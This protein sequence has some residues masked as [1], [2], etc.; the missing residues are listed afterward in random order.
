MKY[1]MYIYDFKSKLFRERV[2]TGDRDGWLDTFMSYTDVRNLYKKSFNEVAELLVERCKAKKLTLDKEL[3][4]EIEYVALEVAYNNDAEIFAQTHIK[5]P[6]LDLM[7][8]K[9]HTY[10]SKDEKGKKFNIRLC[11]YNEND[12][13]VF[14]GY[15]RDIGN[16]YDEYKMFD[17]LR[18]TLEDNYGMLKW[19][20]DYKL[21]MSDGVIKYYLK[22]DKIIWEMTDKQDISDFWSFIR[23]NLPTLEE[24]KR[25][26]SLDTL[27]PE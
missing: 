27:I 5:G 1:A 3:I 10:G 22:E 24:R 7:L 15:Y 25:N 6:N 18:E 20:G 17:G 19:W 14:G 8:V 21:D 4:K 12:E 2:K 11:M 13:Q 9:D 23:I 16:P 26:E